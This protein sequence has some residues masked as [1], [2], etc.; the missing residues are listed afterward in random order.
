[1]ADQPEY[2]VASDSDT[3]TGEDWDVS[4][5]SVNVAFGIDVGSSFCSVAIWKDSGVEVLANPR[6]MKRMPSHV[7]FKGGIPCS[8]VSTAI[9]DT[10][11]YSG[12][13]IYLAKCLLGRADTDQVVQT[14]KNSPFLVE[15]LDIG[16][17]PF[18]AALIDG[19]WRSTSPEEVLAIVLAEL[20]AMAE[21]QL[22]HT[23]RSAVL[24][25]P[26]SFSRFQKTRLERA[27]A[28]AGLHV[29]RLMPEPTAVALLYAQE[30]QKALQGSMGSGIEKNVLIFNAGAGFCDVALAATAG[31]VSQIRAVAG[32]SVGGDSMIQNLV[33]YVVND[34]RSSAEE[35]AGIS[36]ATLSTQLRPAASKAMHA[37]STSQ[38]TVLECE[39]GSKRISKTITREEFEHVNADVFRRCEALAVQC[40]S[41]AQ[42]HVDSLDDVILVGGCSHVPA[43]RSVILKVCAGKQFYE[44][45][46]PTEAAVQGAA[47]EGAIASGLTDTTGRLD[48]LTIQALPHSLGLKVSGREFLPI[49]QK[50][51]AVP[52]RRDVLLT[53]SHSNQTEALIIVYEGEAKQ[54]SD[55]QLLGFFKVTGIPLAQKGVPVINVCMDVDASDVLRVIVGVCLPGVEKPVVPLVEVRM[56]TIEDGHV[57]CADALQIKYGSS[58]ELDVLPLPKPSSSPHAQ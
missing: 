3:A 19:V 28:M 38:S 13:A 53:T 25:M 34:Y 46:N 23:V 49:L 37:L 21:A 6:G 8:G 12:S 57:W 27:C 10:Q 14:C 56:P 41:E 5:S 54:A 24:T 40:V 30:Q 1:M 39:I 17:R 50:N 31:G 52:A 7:L 9:S 48:L 58:L 18:L 2:V 29:L 55:N 22:G 11:L 15:T 47:M 43:I 42:I 16:A 45:I 32:D 26:A 36:F 20:R 4:S 44:G 35:N 51:G 33:K